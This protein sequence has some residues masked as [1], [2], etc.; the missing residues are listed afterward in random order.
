MASLY[1][2]DVPEDAAV[3]DRIVLGGDE[4]RHAIRVARVRTGERISIGDG[5]G[6]IAAGVVVELDEAA[7]TL[8]VDELR[9]EPLPRVHL[10]LV[11]ALAKGG[12]DEAAIQAATELGVAGIVPWAAERSVVRWDAAKSDRAHAR[13]EAIIREAAKQS[14]R[15]R[16]PTI[17]PLAA[18]S[19]LTT[20]PGSTLV[21]DPTAGARLSTVELPDEG[22]LT[23]VV[24][25]EGGIAPHELD[26]LTASGAV[27]VRLGDEVLRTSTAGPAAL[28][29]LNLRLGRW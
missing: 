22:P 16:V 29:A 5:A 24:G 12:R 13:W 14:I 10:Y 17:A 20:R 27:R 2:G 15:A 28:A 23:V 11:Q 6:R 19:E 9:D 21:L 3:G 1:L 8:E 4:A 7:L 26:A 25:P 18:T